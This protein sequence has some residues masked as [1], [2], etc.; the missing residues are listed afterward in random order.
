MRLLTIMTNGK[1]PSLL[2]TTCARLDSEGAYQCD[3]RVVYLDGEDIRS[4]DDVVPEGWDLVRKT[5][6]PI[7]TRRMMWWIFEQALKTDCSDLIFCEDDLLVAKDAIAK[8]L[9]LEVPRDV[10][11]VT[12]FDH[13]EF[14]SARTDG[15]TGLR[16]VVPPGALNTGMW[17]SLCF[18]IP[19]R[20]MEF[21]VPRGSENWGT[22][23]GV[24][25]GNAGDSTLSWAIG[26]S[27]WPKFM[28]HQPSLVDHAAVLSSID[29][30]RRVRRAAWFDAPFDAAREQEIHA[31]TQQI[32]KE[33]SCSCPC[34]C[35]FCDE[36]RPQS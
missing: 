2:G 8:I 22:P 19:R 23:W 28:V 34:P 35:A 15:I 3:S 1:R 31:V 33:S 10:A 13:K 20:T 21:L 4:V 30:T 32:I 18:L 26:Q 29:V 24:A 7:G 27:P 11:F 5:D 36:K 17:G 25:L 14:P 16:P 12:F 9:T 6:G